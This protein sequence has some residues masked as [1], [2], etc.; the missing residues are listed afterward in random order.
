[1]GAPLHTL[2]ANFNGGEMTPLMASRFDSDKLRSGCRT[3]K[4]FIVRPYGG[5]FKRPG[6]Q[7][8]G[9]VKNSANPVR[10][11]PFRRSTSTN[12]I[13]ELGDFYMRLW[14]GGTTPAQVTVSGVTA[15]A[16]STA[17]VVGNLV[18]SSGTN[19]YCITAHTSGG[20][21]SVGSNWY[22]LTGSIFEV[23]T[24]WAKADIFALQY[25]QINDIMF[26]T[27]PSYPPYRLS[28][29]AETN[30]VIDLVP[31]TFAPSLDV[32][33]TRTAV[34]VQYNV[35]IWVTST[36]YSVGTMVANLQTVGLNSFTEIYTCTVAHTSGSSTQPGVGASWQ[37]NWNL[38]TSKTVAAAW[39]TSTS[40]T[41][42]NLVNIGNAT[43]KCNTSHT[44]GSTTQP[45]VGG[46]WATYW[47]IIGGDY[48]NG[49]LTYNLVS[50]SAAF[51]SSDV[52]NT[53]QLQIGSQNYYRTTSLVISPAVVTTKGIF[54][55]GDLL[56][57][58]NWTAGNAP[59]G[60][61]FLESST[62]MTTWT[63]VRE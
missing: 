16:A 44:S 56:V 33:T 32:N 43:Y 25:T 37:S 4:N 20:S 15:W 14:K 53:W 61:L 40:Y 7:Y 10:I 26:F 34:Q 5:V 55:Q 60:A 57:S 47:T 46:Y 49:S 1:M 41:A 58:S 62:D 30:C 8:V 27:H 48:D 13:I 59:I 6:T 35:N 38:G 12:Y 51:T 21:F 19:Y 63:R 22:A 17:Y 39:A 52:G 3:L 31:F 42:G 18:S 36:A 9:A 24:P 11:I 45:G 29:F 2:A 54:I 23:P 28:R 50:T